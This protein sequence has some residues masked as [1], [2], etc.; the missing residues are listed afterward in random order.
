MTPVELQVVGSKASM[1][2]DSGK[3]SG[4][5][6]VAVVKGEDDVRPVSSEQSAVRVGLP[7]DLPSDTKRR[8]KQAFGL[9]RRPLTHATTG[10]EILIST[11]R[12]LCC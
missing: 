11:G 10:K 5:E 12:D 4:G 7:L 9:N 8:Y 3:H 2:L 6:F 1:L